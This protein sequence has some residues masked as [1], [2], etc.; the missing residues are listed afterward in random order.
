MLFKFLYVQDR[1]HTGPMLESLF[2]PRS[3]ELLER[4]RLI[5]FVLCFKN[6][7]FNSLVDTVNEACNLWRVRQNLAERVLGL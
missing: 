2:P 7:R 5:S 4:F 3:D 6:M 1:N